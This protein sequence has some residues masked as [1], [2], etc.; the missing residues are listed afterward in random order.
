[1]AGVDREGLVARVREASGLS[2]KNAEDVVSEFERLV[3]KPIAARLKG[4]K[5]KKIIQNKNPYL[6]R[7][8]GIVSCEDI[9]RR[10]YQ[11]YVSASLEG[12]FGKFFEA[13]A[14]I[15]SGGVKPVGGGEVDLD[16]RVGDNLARLYAIKSGSKGFNSSSHAKAV[17]DLNSAERRLRQDNVKT[18]KK[19]AFAYGRRTGS[20]AA[21]IDTLSSKDFWS[22]VSGDPD[23]YKKLLAVCAA[24]A[25]LYQADIES[26][27]EALF[28]EAHRL[29]C[30]GDVIDWG[31]ILE[32]VSG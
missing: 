16:V 17:D 22:E 19:I 5:L 21:G 4:L 9:V 25:P 14:R 30:T 20:F 26:P 13:V 29:F 31:K 1:V 28:Q 32:L 6:Y 23:F 3:S 10:A 24:L 7:V 11:D 18:D 2:S 15:A 27:L 12:D 8:S